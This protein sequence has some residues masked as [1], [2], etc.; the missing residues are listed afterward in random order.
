VR[1]HV[2]HRLFADD[3]AH[4]HDTSVLLGKKM[5][6]GSVDRF[7]SRLEIDSPDPLHLLRGDF[8]DRTDDTVSGVTDQDVQTTEGAQ[9][10]LHN[11]S[12]GPGN[13][14]ILSMYGDL[15]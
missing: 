3:A 5:G 2:G 15:W 7:I 4:Q 13:A 6:N 14:E 9:T 8:A 12:P 10:L 11:L 1:S